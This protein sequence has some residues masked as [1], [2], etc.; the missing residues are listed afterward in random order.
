MSRQALPVENTPRTI[1][2]S[3]PSWLPESVW[4]RALEEG[5]L[6][7]SVRQSKAER[8][9]MRKRRKIPASTWAERHRVVTQS[10]LPGPWRNSTTPYLAGIMD[11]SLYR[12]VQEIGPAGGRIRGGA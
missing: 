7:I 11:A 1:T 5:R 6:T 12:S 2:V 3:L 9:V 8:K 10:S 4:Q